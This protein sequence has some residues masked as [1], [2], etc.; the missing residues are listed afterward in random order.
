MM[1][2]SEVLRWMTLAH[3]NSRKY[4]VYELSNRRKLIYS[5]DLEYIKSKTLELGI[6]YL[7]E[8][9]MN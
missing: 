2:V 3:N 9:L 5:N 1:V 4:V 8:L 7:V 6:I